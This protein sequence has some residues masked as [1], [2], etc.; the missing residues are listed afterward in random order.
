MRGRWAAGRWVAVALAAVLV[1]GGA[2]AGTIAASRSGEALPGTRVGGQDVG[3]QD[4]AA[5]RATVEALARTRTTGTLAVTA[6]DQTMTVDRSRVTV[7]VPATVLAALDAGRDGPFGW[8][9][10]R[11]ETV[12]LAVELDRPALQAQL[13]AFAG[14]VDRPVREGGFTVAGVAVTPVQ[15]V[16]GRELD[17]AAALTALDQA[18]RSGTASLDL[19]V[20]TETP[21]TTTEDVSA[22][23][24]KARDALAGPYVVGSGTASLRL[25]PA[26]L[27]PMLGAEPVD[28]ALA[29]AVDKVALRAV[30]E[31]QAQDLEIG[32]REAGFTVASAAPVV[33]TK[34]NLTWTPRP[35]AV[36]VTPGVPGREVDLDTATA[37]FIELVV[38]AGRNAPRELPVTVVEPDLTTA[39]A[40]AAKIRTLLGTFTTYFPGGAPRAKNIRRIAEIVDGTYVAPGGVLS[41]ND[42]AGERTLAGGFFADGAIVDGELVNEVGGGVSQFATTLFNAAFFAGLPIPEHKPHSFYIS[43]YPPGRESTVYFGALDV[44]VKN[45][46]ANGLLVKTSSTPGSVTVALYGDNGGRRVSSTTGPRR[47]RDDGGFRISVTRSIAGGDGKGGRRVFTT[48]YDP[49]PVDKRPGARPAPRPGPSPPP[50]PVPRPKATPGVPPPR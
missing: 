33:D 22:V 31:A 14:K 20:T 34:G 4:R 1:A 11:G 2:A 40:E 43:R 26:Q 9:L 45:D 28:G 18:L 41:L 10:G 27:A 7:D 35:A 50:S 39:A 48:S 13:T 23:V 12:P 25:T 46:T 29:L 37:R 44:K 8:L 16:Q 42:A 3:G 5:L 38:V 30:L 47:P 24:V 15:P 6:A 32:A 21:A 36:R 17:R 19:P 49:A